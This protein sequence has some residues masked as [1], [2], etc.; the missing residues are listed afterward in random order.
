M[1]NPT[2]QN[3][4]VNR[5]LTNI[6]IAY[7]QKASS[8]VAGQVFP[9]I[10][11]KKQSDRYFV[12]LKE[13]WFRD[14][15][16][17]RVQGTE[18]AGGGYEIDNTPTYFCETWA[19]HKDVTEEDRAN[20]DSPLAPDRDA[21]Q[22]VTQKLLVK[23]E[24]EWVTR[25]FST[26]LWTTGYTGGAATAGTVKKFWSS[27]GS[28]P[29]E[30][31]ADAQIAI[32]SVTGYKPNVL[33][34]SPYVYKDLRNHADIVDRIKYSGMIPATVNKTTLAE[35]FDVEK[36][37]IA[38]GVVNSAAKGDTE[39]TDFIAGKHALLCY[40][41]PTPGIKQP[42][43]GYTFAWTGLLGSGAFGNRMVTIDMPWL[44]VGTR[45]IEG[46]M[47]FDCKLV[48]ADL[49]AFFEDIVE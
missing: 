36:V 16:M 45:R 17:K 3:I 37:L 48:A 1:P 32:Q 34:L 29:I 2:R 24:I 47:S 35:L 23:K 41:A 25:F 39:D 42:T 10:P 49:G 19:Y 40:A 22:F 28:T 20:S 8:F 6:S 44:G 43:A 9:T 33:T 7:I 14:E 4:H 21:T 18:S 13:D 12:Y 26:A 11:V 30:D 15:A 5:P 38:E 46:E 31:I 27:S